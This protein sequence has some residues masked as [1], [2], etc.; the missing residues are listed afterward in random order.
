MVRWMLSD[1]KNFIATNICR[2]TF[3][4]NFPIKYEEE[5]F[6]SLLRNKNSGNILLKFPLIKAC[7]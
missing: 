7:W 6:K 3:K 1:D 2:K 4:K 5:T